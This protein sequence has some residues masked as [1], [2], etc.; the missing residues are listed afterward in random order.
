MGSRE[1]VSSVL[2]AVE[3]KLVSKYG[4]K[5]DVKLHEQY[6][7]SGCE[8]FNYKEPCASEG[9]CTMQMYLLIYYS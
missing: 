7:H 1:E 3:V 5:S 2:E 6:C 9:P 4:N 8:V